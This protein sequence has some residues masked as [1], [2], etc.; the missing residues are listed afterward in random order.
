MGMLVN[1]SQKRTKRAALS[2]ASM[3]RH[4]G[5][6]FGLVGDHTDGMS[7][8]VTKADDDVLRPFCLNFHEPTVVQDLR[9]NIQDAVGF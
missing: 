6:D 2:L 5:E 7:T 3:S 4:P 8:E 9:N 1:A